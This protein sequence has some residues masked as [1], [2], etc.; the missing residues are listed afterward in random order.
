MKIFDMRRL[1]MCLTAVFLSFPLSAK[2]NIDPGNYEV[3]L[4][5]ANLEGIFNQIEGQTPITFAYNEIIDENTRVNIREGKQNLKT[6][7][8]QISSQ[9]NITFNFV[10]NTAYVVPKENKPAKQQSIRVNGTVRDD[11]N[12]PL[13]GATVVEKGTNNG[14]STDFDGN[15]SIDVSGPGAI[16]RVSYMGFTP[17]E[18]EV[19]ESS[20]LEIVL[21]E[22]RNVLDEV[23]VVGYGT[24]KKANLTGAVSQVSGEDLDNRPITN[25]NSGLQGLLPGVTITGASGAPGNN[26]GNIRIRGVGTWGDANPLVVIDGVPGGNLNI[27]NPKDIESVSVLKDAASSSIYGVR[28]A[29]G[30]ILVTTK[31]GS[32]GK[33][34]LSYDF[35]YGFQNPT[36]LPDRLGSPEYME[37][38]NESQVNVGRNPTYTEDEIRIAREGTDPDNYA[39]TNWI[40]EVYKDYAPQENHNLAINGGSENLNYYLSYGYLKEGGLIT[41]DNYNS[42]RNNTRVKINTTLFDHLDVT[43]NLGYVDRNFSGSSQD[44][45]PL[46]QALTIIPL[47]PVRNSAGGWGYIGGSSNPV[48]VASDAGTSDFSSEEFT[49]NIQAVLN[50]FD[51]FK[52][53]ARYGLVKYN[54]RKNVFERTINYYSPETGDLL[55]QTGYPNKIT[56]S[57]Y[58][59]IYQ[60][61]IGTAEYEKNFSDVH[62]VKFL[63]G[64]SQ[65]ETINDD[66][67]ASRT[68]LASSSTG[69]INLGTENQLNSGSHKENALQSVFGRANYAFKDKYL[70]EIDF[71]YD[72]SSR[73]SDS[74][75]WELFSAA[76]LGWVFTKESFL[77]N[78]GP[79]NYGK[80]RAS[81]GTQGNDRIADLAYLDILGPITTMPIGNELT[82]G[83]R[84]T[85]V[86][87]QM[88][89]WETSKKTDIGLDLGFFK[90]RLLLNFDYYINKTDNILLRLPIPDIFGG[91]DYP[92]QNAGSVENKG[93]EL[94]L[95]WQDQVKD[96]SYNL[97]FNFSDVRNKVVDLGGTEPT[98][99]DRI[100][101]IGEPLDAFYGLVADR[102]AQE[103]DFTYNEADG[104]YTPNFPYIDGDPVQP[105]DLIYKDLNGDGEVDLVNDRKVIGSHIPRYTFGFRGAAAFRGFDFS[106]FLQGVGKA[107]GLL[108]GPARHAFISESA[109]PQDIHLDRWTPENTD[110]GYPR[111]TYQQSYNQR[112]ST[113]WLEDASYIRLKNIQLGYTLPASV[114]E[115]F[116]ATKLRIYFSADNLFT[117][118]DY[119]KGY[120]PESPVDNVKDPVTNGQ[121]YPQLKTFVFGLNVTFR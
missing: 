18:V 68:N 109:M 87:N 86:G 29:N 28:G 36:A 119:F 67:G 21:T 73:F 41:G 93:W 66:L 59:G 47:V 14:V 26:A 95:G 120:D 52:V 98:L 97:N 5:K 13:A 81:Y 113:Y 42:E 83:Y 50:V 115:K 25:L 53:T 110:A 20:N 33:P 116:R 7:L 4:K 54:S 15:F 112:L 55:W 27:L 121:F 114:T 19:S 72:G 99:G 96:F 117:I 49:G 11:Q 8:R 6:C 79:L 62:H 12:L 92:Y 46:Y 89:T 100:R 32:M 43:A 65:E 105:G 37:L 10:E 38:L 75:R 102:I 30:V 94:Q 3:T 23:L 101:M 69:H 44:M 85:I 77:E 70:A 51:G 16:L 58:K 24:Q 2:Q 82:I 84:Q 31:K 45:G 71:R 107:D 63:V 39:N 88:L 34:S 60:T 104:T 1:L 40:K 57:S 103:S 80:I 78:L 106:F 91:P 111:L 56:T 108:T 61:F 76:S 64:A 22:D 48:A 17:Y 9:L 90:N 118:T 74:V 35:Y